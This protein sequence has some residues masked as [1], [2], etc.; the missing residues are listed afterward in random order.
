MSPDPD[1]ACAAACAAYGS[2][3]AIRSMATQVALALRTSEAH[4]DLATQANEDPLT[5]LGNRRAFDE[6]LT[7][8]IAR[9]DR[10]G[11][12]LAIGLLGMCALI[13]RRA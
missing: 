8:E 9:S 13:I 12:P 2:A 7:V 11:S 10:E 3:V 5:G 6:T 1:S 4:H